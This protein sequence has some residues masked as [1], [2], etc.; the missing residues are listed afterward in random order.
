MTHILGRNHLLSTCFGLVMVTAAGIQA[1]GAALV[2][3]ILAACAVL[4]GMR[5]RVAATLAVLLAAAVIMLIDAEPLLTGAAGLSAACYL[6]LRHTER[7]LSRS[8]AVSPSAMLTAMGFTVISVV[9]ASIP[10][11]LPWLPLLAPPTVF[12]AYVLATWPYF[13]DT[14]EAEA[15]AETH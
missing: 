10:F 7:G 15:E 8:A 14:T 13:F 11:Q 12:A 9:A 3:A 1:A 6:V 4:A 2:V 5:F